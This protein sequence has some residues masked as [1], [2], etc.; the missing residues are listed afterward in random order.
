M[1]FSASWLIHCRNREKTTL[2]LVSSRKP[3]KN[4]WGSS[5]DK[6]IAFIQRNRVSVAS[7][8]HGGLDFFLKKFISAEFLFHGYE[9]QQAATKKGGD[10]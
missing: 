10:R 4:R 2:C 9:I 5:P 6:K 7:P 3:G 8:R 1:R